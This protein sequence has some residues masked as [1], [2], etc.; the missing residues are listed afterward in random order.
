ML[1][2]RTKGPITSRTRAFGLHLEERYSVLAILLPSLIL[3]LLILA[4]SG[5]FIEFWLRRH[6]NDLQNAA[7]P[8][9]LAVSALTMAINIPISLLIFRWT[10]MGSG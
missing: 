9:N 2:V 3:A 4:P 6:P 5:W 8:I 10:I 7:V 1:P